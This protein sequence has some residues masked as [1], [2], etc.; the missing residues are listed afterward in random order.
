[1]SSKEVETVLEHATHKAKQSFV[2]AITRNTLVL[3]SIVAA[4]AICV[5]LFFKTKAL[6]VSTVECQDKSCGSDP[7]RCCI[8]FEDSKLSLYMPAEKNNA[9]AGTK[10]ECV[11]TSNVWTTSVLFHY[12]KTPLTTKKRVQL[13]LMLWTIALLW[14]LY[15]CTKVYV[16]RNDVCLKREL[17][18]KILERGA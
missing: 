8:T 4:L 5:F 1:M 18:E 7:R 12:G 14:Q 6:T 13:C 11:E 16:S 17:L 3:G 9:E 10:I 2:L 15:F